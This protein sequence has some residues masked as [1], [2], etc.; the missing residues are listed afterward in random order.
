MSLPPVTLDDLTQATLIDPANDLLLVRQGF[1]DKKATVDQIAAINLSTLPLIPSSLQALDRIVVARPV[2]LGFINYY[3]TLEYFG[4]PSGTKMYFYQSTPPAGW[5]ID[6]TVQDRLLAVKG[7]AGSIYENSGLAGTWQ[8]TSYALT[9]AQIP[10]HVH[11]MPMGYEETDSTVN[12]N[13]ARAARNIRTANSVFTANGVIGI[14]ESAQLLGQ[15]HNHGNIWR[16][17]AAVGCIGTKN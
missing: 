5:T 14:G 6:N 8:Q 3:A 17:A 16:P 7:T 9:P 10:P 2:G 13:S 1:Q 15:G 4:F 12:L 11:K